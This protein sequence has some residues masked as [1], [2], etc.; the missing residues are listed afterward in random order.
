MALF[1]GA[2]SSSNTQTTIVIPPTVETID[3]GGKVKIMQCEPRIKID[4]KQLFHNTGKTKRLLHKN[5]K[6][7]AAMLIEKQQKVQFYSLSF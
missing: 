6:K 5:K 4:E 1:E 7:I 2:F 3:Y